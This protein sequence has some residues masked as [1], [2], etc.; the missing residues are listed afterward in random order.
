[1][2]VYNKLSV[3]WQLLIQIS[4]SRFTDMYEDD[5]SSTTTADESYESNED[6]GF[7]D[8]EA[9]DGQNMDSTL[10]C[11]DANSNSSEDDNDFVLDLDVKNQQRM[12]LTSLLYSRALERKL[13][14]LQKR[15]PSYMLEVYKH[16]AT[17]LK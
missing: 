9:L 4:M 15:K 10:E 6:S 1:M 16:E 7:A 12:T 2:I 5:T 17:K 3:F 14:P 8:D 11:S 13:K